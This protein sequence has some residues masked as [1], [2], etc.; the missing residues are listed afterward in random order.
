MESAHEGDLVALGWDGASIDPV[1]ALESTGIG[2]MEANLKYVDTILLNLVLF[3][4]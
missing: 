4:G 3:T 1:L 2:R